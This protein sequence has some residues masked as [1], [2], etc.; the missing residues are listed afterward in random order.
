MS[1]DGTIR[2]WEMDTF[3]EIARF[4][5]QT[6]LKTF[7]FSLN[8]RYIFTITR[9]SIVHSVDIFSHY[10]ESFITDST[11]NRN[12]TAISCIEYAKDCYIATGT[13]EG[14]I[15]LWKKV[16]ETYKRQKSFF[17]KEYVQ[18]VTFSPDGHYMVSTGEK[19]TVFIWEV[20]T[21]EQKSIYRYTSCIISL[22]FDSTSTFLA[23]ADEEHIIH[24]VDITKQTVTHLHT[25]TS[26]STL[27]F[28]HNSLFLAAGMENGGIRVWEKTTHVWQDLYSPEQGSIYDLRWSQDNTSFISVSNSGLLRLWKWTG[29]IHAIPTHDDLFRKSK[30]LAS[31]RSS[32]NDL[33]ITDFDDHTTYTWDISNGYQIAACFHQGTTTA[34]AISPDDQYIAIVC[35]DNTITIWQI[36]T[37]YQIVQI[38]QPESI[39][40]ISFSADGTHLIGT[41]KHKVY[42]WLWQ[43]QDM[44]SA[45]HALFK[46]EDDMH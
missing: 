39:C 26:I 6:H 27:A 29:D 45:A 43:P 32:T 44:I 2:I 12:I 4:P 7:A 5:V 28:S 42:A 38:I 40:T 13:E 24:V 21:W 22:T 33:F 20:P 18:S 1:E 36:D 30:C 15:F 31:V 25:E 3:R 16:N 8:G 10:M 9:Y 34:L 46:I 11:I 41:G 19:G 14:E 35:D 23:S 17:V 37:S